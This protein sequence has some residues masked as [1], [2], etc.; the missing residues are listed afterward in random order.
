M[1]SAL[2][3]F[4]WAVL[5]CALWATAGSS[6]PPECLE[7]DC[8][9]AEVWQMYDASKIGNKFSEPT[10]TREWNEQTKEFGPVLQVAKGK[11][12]FGKDVTHRVYAPLCNRGVPYDVEGNNKRLYYDENW[13]P[14]CK[15]GGAQ[16]N[17]GA[18]F[19]PLQFNAKSIKY[20][21]S[22]TYDKY[23]KCGMKTPSPRE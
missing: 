20:V 5:V 17:S 10:V 7:C 16:G 2:L 4:C 8:V 12:T 21:A 6:N 22:I 18:H 15:L 19:R 1:R 13:D 14:L 11:I 9:E 23:S 3:C